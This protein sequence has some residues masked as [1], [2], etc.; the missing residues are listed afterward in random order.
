MIDPLAVNIRV[1]LPSLISGHQTESCMLSL[2][3]RQEDDKIHVML[4]TEESLGLRCSV[5][6]PC[7]CS[8]TKS[9]WLC[10]PMDCS[11]PG[12]PALH[13]PWTCPN[14]CPL[15]RWCHPTASSSVAPGTYL[16][17][18]ETKPGGQAWLPLFSACVTLASGLHLFCVSSMSHQMGKAIST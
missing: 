4:E 1:Q 2:E 5:H 17:L 11:T 18:D 3:Q 13:R 16:I 15:S 6:G 9:C 14:S 7:C 8:V 10:D 12:F